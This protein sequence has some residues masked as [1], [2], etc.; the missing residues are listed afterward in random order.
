MRLGGAPVTVLWNTVLLNLG[1]KNIENRSAG[2]VLLNDGRKLRFG[3][4]KMFPFGKLGI[5]GNASW[6]QK[7]EDV[8]GFSS[9]AENAISTLL[10]DLRV[11]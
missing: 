2:Y 7:H 6:I 5:I 9:D 1:G 10:C 8:T 3:K 4:C 11:C